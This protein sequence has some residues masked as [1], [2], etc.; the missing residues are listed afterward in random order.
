MSESFFWSVLFGCFLVGVVS[1]TANN[2][3]R[4]WKQ[5]VPCTEVKQ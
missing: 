1:C 2:V 3:Y 5:P 4:E